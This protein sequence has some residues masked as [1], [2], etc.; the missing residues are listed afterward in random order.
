MTLSMFFPSIH[1]LCHLT[2]SFDFAS[3]TS[4]SLASV[5]ELSSVVEGSAALV[6]IYEGGDGRG[7]AMLELAEWP[8]ERDGRGRKTVASLRAGPSLYVTAGIK[9]AKREPSVWAGANRCTG[10]TRPN[11]L[12]SPQSN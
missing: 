4:P 9:G 1:F 5:S 2:S 6:A 11:R 12:S 10:Q 8:R 3:R 7:G